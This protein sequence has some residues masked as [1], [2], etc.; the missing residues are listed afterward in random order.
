MILGLLVQDQW[1]LW[2][3][4]PVPLATLSMEVII[5]LVGVIECGVGQLQCVRVSRMYVLFAFVKYF[6]ISMKNGAFAI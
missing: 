5:G 4:T 1:E 2:P 6:Q 3:P